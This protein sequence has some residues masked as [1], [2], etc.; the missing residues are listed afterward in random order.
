MLFAITLY[1][2]ASA[3]AFQA[4]IQCSSAPTLIPGVAKELRYVPIPGGYRVVVY[5]GRNEISGRVLTIDGY[6]S[7]ISNFIA[8]D[9][10][11]NLANTRLEYLNSPSNLRNR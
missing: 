1:L 8:A 9:R 6:I 2:I 7:G 4:D 5:G 10:D 3:S 11:A